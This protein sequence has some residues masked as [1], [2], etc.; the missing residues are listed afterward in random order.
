[1]SGSPLLPCLITLQALGA[2]GV[3]LN[4]S[5]GLTGMDE[6]IGAV[7]PH[8][9]VPLIA[10]P[11]A[12]MKD[13]VGFDQNLDP[14]AFAQG[15][16]ILMDAGASIVGG[17]CGTTPPIWPLCAGWRTGIPPWRRRKSMW[18][19]RRANAAPFS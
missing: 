16:E 7:L 1:M 4:C 15:M 18:T 10:K 2:A 9:A 8:A 14:D 12:M 19:P 3:G 6:W 17:C 11:N 13:A 5:T